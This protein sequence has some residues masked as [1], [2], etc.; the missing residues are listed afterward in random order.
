MKK[1]LY[2]RQCKLQRG[3]THQT[4]WIPEQFAILN[5]VLKLKNGEEWEDG[6]VVK[7]V[8]SRLE[9]KMLP[10]WR[11]YYHGEGPCGKW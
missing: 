10:N 6:W 8:W 5:K 2:Y 9:E 11:N 4:S 7:E 3:N 1:E